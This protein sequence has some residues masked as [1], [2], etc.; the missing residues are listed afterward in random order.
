MKS[1]VFD[2]AFNSLPFH[3]PSSPL[4]TAVCMQLQFYVRMMDLL[5]ACIT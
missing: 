2:L 5:L 3:Q 1:V 4:P